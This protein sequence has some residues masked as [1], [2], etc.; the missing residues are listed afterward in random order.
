MSDFD[1]LVKGRKMTRAFTP[2]SVDPEIVNR[3]V[4]LARRGPSAGKTESLHFLV[5]EGD[6]VA[7]Y[8]H[9]TLAPEKRASFPW[10][11]LLDAP[12]LIVPWVEP[13]AYVRR[14][15]EPDKAST[16]LGTAQDAWSVPY[17]WVDGGAAA[18]TVLLAVEDEG[19]GALLFGLFEHE[20]AV[21]D[22]FGVP[23]GFRAIGAIAI[24]HPAPDR[25]SMSASRR[26][27]PFR[28]VVHRGDW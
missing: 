10:P 22:E 11:H 14:Y 26:R 2:D 13:G 28:E 4:D 5:L 25:P 3:I 23:D 1:R 24:G 27:P 7:R 9:T 8:W 16:G 21:R 12:V 15:A 20:R 18:M 17:W 6:D 19:L